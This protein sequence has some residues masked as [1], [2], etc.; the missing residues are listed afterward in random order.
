MTRLALLAVLLAIPAMTGPAG[1][2]VPTPAGNTAARATLEIVLTSPLTVAGQGFKPKER[3]RVSANGRRKSV[4]AGAR[5]SFEVAFR[6]ANVCNGV[7]VVAV[8]SKGS[9]ASVTFAQFSDVH[10]LEPV[11]T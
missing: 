10:C 8:G 6:A 9:R 2:A 7:V 5:G 11:E 3:I 4:T 1:G